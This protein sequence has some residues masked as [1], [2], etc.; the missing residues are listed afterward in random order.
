[1]T[2]GNGLP[3]RL[4]AILAEAFGAQLAE[5]DVSEA[6]ELEDR[7]WDATL[8]CE[9]EHLTGDLNWSLS[10][11]AGDEVT[12]QPS[13]EQLALHFARCLSAPVFFEWDGALPWIRKVALPSGTTTL[14]RVLQSDCSGSDASVESAEAPIAAFPHLSV[15]RFPE[16]VRAFNIQTPLTDSARLTE[17]DEKP[18]SIRALLGNWERLCVRLRSGWPPD[19]WYSADLYQ[20]D[21]EFRDQLDSAVSELSETERKAAEAAVRELDAVYRD[22]TVDDQ[23][24]ALTTA[25]KHEV[26]DLNGRAWYWH[27]RPTELPWARV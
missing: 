23:G 3:E 19:G 9:Y 6:S 5:I 4:P 2:I 14:A 27:R 15:Q 21:L 10:V 20:E 7:N 16:V 26:G 17:P 8:T 11:Y 13:D 1:M 24:L 18:V 25:V 22:L 12:H